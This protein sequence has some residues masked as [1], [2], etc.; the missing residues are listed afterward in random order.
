V[1]LCLIALAFEMMPMIDPVNYEELTMTKEALI[2]LFPQ[3]TAVSNSL[4]GS[5][6]EVD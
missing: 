3:R 5:I 1:N 6:M 4:S 2:M